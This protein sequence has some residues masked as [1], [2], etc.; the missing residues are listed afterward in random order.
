MRLHGL[1][2]SAGQGVPLVGIVYDQKVGSFLSYIGQNLYE[3]LHAVSEESLKKLIDGAVEL[4]NDPTF[5][6]E[7]VEK[8]RQ[9]EAVNRQVAEQ[10]VK[11]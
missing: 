7:S 1:I 9:M 5:L 8:L 11:D 4:S 3:D 6:S 2:F 10:Y